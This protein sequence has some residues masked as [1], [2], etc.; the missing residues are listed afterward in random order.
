MTRWP[1]LWLVLSAAAAAGCAGAAARSEDRTG[2]L[3]ADLTS[4]DEAVR[5][6][7]A[8]A[9]VA[10]GP[11]VLF[12]LCPFIREHL[13]DPTEHAWRAAFAVEE[14]IARRYQDDPHLDDYY[15]TLP[16]VPL[17]MIRVDLPGGLMMAFVRIP[18]GTFIQG[19]SNPG[20]GIVMA[21]DMPCDYAP[22]RKVTLT[23]PFWIGRDEVSQEQ[24][25][26]LM[27]VNRCREKV[28]H[29]P[30]DTISWGEA[31]AFCRKLSERHP[32]WR[33]T[34]PTEAQWEYACRAGT[35]SRHAFGNRRLLKGDYRLREGGAWYEN[36]F[37]LRAM[38]HSVFEWC[39]DGFGPT[40]SDPAV[41]PAGP[42]HGV[43]RSVRSNY[44]FCSAADCRSA[45]RS[46]FPDRPRNGIGF[47]V[48]CTPS[49]PGRRGPGGED[50][51]EE[52][53]CQTSQDD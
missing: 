19:S 1:A 49:S 22:V 34:L 8:R 5:A 11:S 53:V 40:S 15:R 32:R 31:T 37:G 17:P 7:A 27:D 25:A 2:A 45:H 6:A 30:V 10:I 18:A 42:A 43:H 3:L 28:P 46:G 20:T 29:L 4:T 21:A 47:R 24:W 51:L 41:D 33:F 39:R 9:L 52:D 48:V 23:E 44:R 14:Q 36:R 16:P 12:R 13:D 38:H 35:T 26:S 50:L